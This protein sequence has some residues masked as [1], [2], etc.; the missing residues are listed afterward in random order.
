LKK[1]QIIREIIG[2]NLRDYGFRFFKTDGACRIFIR[3]VQ[4]VKRYYNPE[5]QVVKQYVSIQ[6]SNFSKA[7][8]ARFYTDAYG[9]EMTHELEELRKYGTGGW[10]K[11]VNEDDYKEKLQFLAR[12]IIEYGLDLLEKISYEEEIIPTKIMAE[13]LFNQ[14][15]QLELDFIEEFDVKAVAETQEEIDEWFQLIKEL[16]ANA[17]EI[18]YEEVKELLTKIA[19]FIG[20]KLCDIHSYKWEFPEYFKTPEIIADYPYPCFFPLDTVVNIWK[21]KCND[22]SWKKMEEQIKVLKQGIEK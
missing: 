12:L 18:P 17:V 21:C 6:E 4:G 3:E 8:I 20:E 14:H 19:A 11:Y 7:L 10:I 1:T 13:K 15:K 5:N 2:E 16:I 22:C 9:Y